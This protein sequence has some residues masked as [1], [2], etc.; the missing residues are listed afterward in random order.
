MENGSQEW[1]TVPGSFKQCTQAGRQQVNFIN[2]IYYLFVTSSFDITFKID[3]IH[4][5][6]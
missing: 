2:V 3:I 4:E 1:K 6:W 5:I